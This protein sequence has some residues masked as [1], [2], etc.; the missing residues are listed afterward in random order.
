MYDG[1]A[2]DFVR[3]GQSGDTT[4]AWDCITTADVQA[5]GHRRISQALHIVIGRPPPPGK[6]P[7]V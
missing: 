1:K 3:A 7:A 2:A 5:V 4:S 6:V